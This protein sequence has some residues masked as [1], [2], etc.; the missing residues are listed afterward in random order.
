MRSFIRL[1]DTLNKGLAI[2]C[3][4]ALAAMT[5]LI[6]LQVLVRFVFT[7]LQIQFS[8]PWTEELSRYL[9]IWAV[10]VGAAVIARRADALAV[11]ALVLAVPARMGRVIKY[12][13]HLLALAFYAC[14][15]VLGLDWMEFGRSEDAPVLGIHM[16]WVYA[17]LS[18]GAALTIINGLTLLVEVWLDKKDIL[19]VVDNEAEEVVQEMD[20]SVS[21]QKA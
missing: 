3:G 6:F 16:A 17:S 11:E 7:K 9:M 21:P 20:L 13:A 5:A 18:V 8:V 15:F 19:D 10:F 14:I 4:L 1:V 2:F 12:S